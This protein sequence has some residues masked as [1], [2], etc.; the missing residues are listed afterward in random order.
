LLDQSQSALSLSLHFPVA[1][2]RLFDQLY[3]HI[4]TRVVF[5]QATLVLLFWQNLG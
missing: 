2:A 3:T 4:R 1:I 5:D